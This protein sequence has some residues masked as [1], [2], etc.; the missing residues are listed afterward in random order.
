MA[1]SL[2]VRVA[3][4]LAELKRNLKEGESA[5]QT[6]GEAASR[7]SEKTKTLSSSYRDF[8]GVLRAAGINIGPQVKALTDLQAAAGAGAV[9]IGAMGVAGLVLGTGIAA[10][11]IGRTAMEF[12]DLDKNVEGA[13]RTLLGFGD[14]A[15][16]AAA[17]KMD[18]L[19]R[20]SAI[21]KR[22]ITDMAEAL[23]IIEK[24][25]KR[26]GEAN[27]N[28]RGI[29]VEANWAV[30]GL[31]ESQIR[32][33]EVAKEAGATTEQLTEK[34]GLSALALKVLADR[35]KEA[36]AA[37]EEH[38]KAQEALI[39]NFDDARSNAM[40]K[41]HAQ[42]AAD[43]EAAMQRRITN[44]E[45]VR[46]ME[47]EAHQMQ[48]AESESRA[49]AE[50]TY[51]AQ[52]IAANQA[53]IDAVLAAAGAHREAGTVAKQA[54]DQTTA[55]WQGIAQQVTITGDAI[56]EWI[57]LMAYSAKA[58]AILSENSLF[59]STSQLQRIAA[60]PTRA[61]GGPVSAGS[62]YMVG[63]RGPEMFV[64]ERSG[65]IV[66]NGAGGQ[67][68]NNITIHV[69]G[70]MLSTAAQLRDVVGGAILDIYKSGAAP[71]PANT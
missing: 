69:D 70:S 1:P 16:E 61:S 7:V 66:P 5:I 33:I 37:A 55:G 15:K 34:Y 47:A 63:E 59:T 67:T 57:N 35:Q 42:E 21:A 13:W 14:A 24:D 25:F 9:A 12:L 52:R 38:R 36:T 6:M 27:V 26:A 22:E 44:E 53:E 39:K 58:N 43:M 62:P 48:L 18:T 23:K 65:A 10:W 2:V 41:M 31:T 64:P 29:L 30:N 20:A 28:W 71:M 3:G 60:I 51:E 50:A 32:E 46:R 45:G 11:K 56:K 19:A 8:D 49:A 68:I 54:S 40:K 4:N 17:N